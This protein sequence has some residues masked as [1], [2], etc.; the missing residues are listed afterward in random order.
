MIKNNTTPIAAL[1]FLATIFFASRITFQDE[2][3][4]TVHSYKPTLTEITTTRDAPKKIEEQIARLETA[5]AIHLEDEAIARNNNILIDE[6]IDDNLQIS[7]LIDM[8]TSLNKLPDDIFLVDKNAWTKLIHALENG[9]PSLSETKT[10]PILNCY[11]SFRR[12]T[13][14]LKMRGHHVN[15]IDIQHI[16]ALFFGDK[17]FNLLFSSEI[18]IRGALA[19][20]SSTLLNANTTSKHQSDQV[21]RD[22]SCPIE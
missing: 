12:H 2:K 10:I 16:E 8:G 18:A 4:P 17:W 9:F 6:A 21:L 14:Q 3:P 7:R 11:R 19:E 5:I 13:N 15:D 1:L 20:G 22:D